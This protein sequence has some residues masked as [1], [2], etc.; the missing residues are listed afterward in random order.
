MQTVQLHNTIKEFGYQFLSDFGQLQPMTQEEADLFVAK[1]LIL[2]NH[3]QR[4]KQTL[5]TPRTNAKNNS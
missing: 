4:I 5:N 2:V 1:R 3:D